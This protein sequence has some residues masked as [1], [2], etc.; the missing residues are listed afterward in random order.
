VS[1]GVLRE[2]EVVLTE[3]LEPG[4]VVVTEGPEALATGMNVREAAL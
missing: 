3:G 4:E 1:V 2:D